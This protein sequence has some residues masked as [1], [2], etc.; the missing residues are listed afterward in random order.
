MREINCEHLLHGRSG[1]PVRSVFAASRIP[2][3]MRMAS[4]T[5]AAFRR[6][7]LERR[8]LNLTQIGNGRLS[9][10]RYLAKDCFFSPE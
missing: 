10:S 1:A 5:A 4:C 9:R 6:G 7:F 3:P 8:R 2:W